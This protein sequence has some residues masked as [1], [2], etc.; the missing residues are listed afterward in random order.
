MEAVPK[1]RGHCEVP[2]RT[3]ARYKSRTVTGLRAVGMMRREAQE[4]AQAPQSA[5]KQQSE[6]QHFMATLIKSHRRAFGSQVS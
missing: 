6:R 3:T 2:G 1:F 5:L 4:L